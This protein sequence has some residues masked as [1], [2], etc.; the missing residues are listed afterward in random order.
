MH[1]SSVGDRRV[2]GGEEVARECERTLTDRWSLHAVSFDGW[3]GELVNIH[4]PRPPALSAVSAQHIQCS[5]H[6]FR[7]L[8]T[9]EDI[10]HHP[11]DA[12]PEHLEIN[13]EAFQVVPVF[14]KPHNHK[15]I[16]DNGSNYIGSMSVPQHSSG[17]GR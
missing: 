3:S 14:E 17:S 16:D 1:I 4:G 5:N 15:H 8:A 11:A 13:M 2:A 10:I 9:D 7:E 6:N 12:L